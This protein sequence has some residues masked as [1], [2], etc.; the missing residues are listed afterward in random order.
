MSAPVNRIC[1]W[2]GAEFVYEGRYH[3]LLYCSKKCARAS[4]SNTNRLPAGERQRVPV[5]RRFLRSHD[6]AECVVLA[7]ARGLPFAEAIRE[8]EAIGQ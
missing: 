7:D 8:L 3:R 2:C 5:G 6:G 4:S 1:K